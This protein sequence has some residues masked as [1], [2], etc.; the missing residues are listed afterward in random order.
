M[1]I[2]LTQKTHNNFKTSPK[3]PF[4]EYIFIFDTKKMVSK[5]RLRRKETERATERY[6]ETLLT[7]RVDPF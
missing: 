4:Q 5:R 2:K 1:I 6:N 7:L 3:T